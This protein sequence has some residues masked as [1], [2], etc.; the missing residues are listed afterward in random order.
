MNNFGNQFVSGAGT[1]CDTAANS[2]GQQIVDGTASGTTV[3]GGVAGAS[4]ALDKKEGLEWPT[5]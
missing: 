1:A 2:G 4:N 3:N 5:K